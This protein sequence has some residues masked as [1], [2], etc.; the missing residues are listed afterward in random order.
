MKVGGRRLL[1]VPPDLAYGST[2]VGPIGPDE[3]L[4]FVVD[5][6]GVQP[7][8]PAADPADEPEV[9]LPATV[10]T[11]LVVED[12][13]VGDGDV[14]EA[15]DDV[16]LNYVGVAMSTG[17]VFDSSWQRGRAVVFPIGE[18]RLIPGWDQGVLGMREGGRRV[19]VIPPDL[20]YGEQGSA[21]GAVGP[22]ETLVFVI[23]VIEVRK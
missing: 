17:D 8:P 1:V 13:A 19:L 15:G 12:V 6:V 18:G 11:E 23:D 9:P 16:V 14:V 5:L 20:A 2:G 21:S 22:D 10:P 7:A 3:T 4:V